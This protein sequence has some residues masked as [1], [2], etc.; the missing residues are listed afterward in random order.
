MS[1]TIRLPGD[2]MKPILTIALKGLLILSCL[3]QAAIAAPPPQT[4]PDVSAFSLSSYPE[5]RSVRQI[6]KIDGRALTYTVSIG[7]IPVRDAQGA[8]IGALSYIAYTMPPRSGEK[9]PVTFAMNGGPGSSSAGIN[10]KGLG[11]KRV[12]L[13]PGQPAR[14]VVIDNADSWLPFTDLVFLDAMGT[15]YSRSF[16]P[17]TESR[18]AFYQHESDVRYLAQSIQSWLQSND[19]AGSD[20]YLVGESYSGYR[21]PRILAYLNDELSTPFDGLVL[22]SPLM[23]QDQSKQIEILPSPTPWIASLV[24]AAAA[25]LD[26]QGKLSAASM[27][28]IEQFARTDYA[29][30]LLEGRTHPERLAQLVDIL[31]PMTGLSREY[32]L[33]TGGKVEPQSYLQEIYKSRGQLAN[34]F[35]TTI[36]Y[37]NPFP[38]PNDDGTVFAALVDDTNP[39][40]TSDMTSFISDTLKWKPT[41]PY[42]GFSFDVNRSFVWA[43]NT[44]SNESYS[45]LRRLLAQ[46]SHLR[47]ML[48]HGYSDIACP[49]FA[50]ILAIEQIPTEA[51]RGRVK[52]STYPGGHMFYNRTASLR[53]FTQDAKDMYIQ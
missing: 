47:V 32:L 51:G 41:I 28:P 9:R 29:L 25:Q 15:G 35:D 13:D 22:L 6:L 50:D 49:Y 4:A 21:A 24:S 3:S 30:Y 12:V 5:Q 19:R 8:I 37:P 45:T 27:A 46:N 31:V 43:R 1:L 34:Y 26:R 53:A 20:K 10:M 23:N 2:R 44:D 18:R 11:P 38:V 16:L 36:A 14:H 48:A 33:K 7:V 39:E 17:E 52:I 40:V 42:M